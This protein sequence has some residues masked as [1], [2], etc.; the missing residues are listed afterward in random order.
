MATTSSDDPTVRTPEFRLEDIPLSSTWI[1]VGQPGSG[2]STMI[3]NLCYYLK[4]RYPV[5]RIFTGTPDGFKDMSDIFHPIFVSKDYDETKENMHIVRQKKCV[6]QNGEKYIGNYAINVID[7]ATSAKAF[8]SKTF[9]GLFKIGS[10]HWA[11]LFIIGT[12]YAIDL[13]PALRKTVSYVAIFF[14]PEIPER[15]KLYR[16]FG[17]LAGSFENFCKLMDDIT[18]DHTCLVFKKRTQAYGIENNISWYQTEVLGKWKFGCKEYRDWG[19]AR[20]NT[21]YDEST[22]M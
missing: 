2:K 12:Q 21:N 3:E 20:Y 4:H 19:D 9:E 11:Q 1:I 7:D 15:E 5:A 6:E 8:K 22:H 16:N 13:P 10:R 14:E 18:G 17:G